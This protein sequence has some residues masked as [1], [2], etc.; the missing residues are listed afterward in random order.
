MTAPTRTSATPTGATL[1]AWPAVRIIAGREISVKIRDKTFIGSTAFLIVVIILLTVLPAILDGGAPDIRVGTVGDTALSVTR[2]AA[3]FG[4][5]AISE[6]ETALPG[7]KL[8]ISEYPDLAAAKRAVDAE[9]IAA[10]VTVSGG[11]LVIV[12]SQSVPDELQELVSAAWTRHQVAA[13]AA[14]LGLTT[15]QV[16]P[17]LS[18]AP[19]ETQLLNARPEGSVPP[20][21]IA[22]IFGF[23]YYLAS[24]LFGNAIA[25][26]VVEEKQSRVVELLVAT[27]RVRQLLAGKVLAATVLALGQVVLLVGLG[28]AG[29]AVTGNTEM[30]SQILPLSGWFLVFFA[31]GMVL[32]ACLWAVSGALASRIE[33]LQSTSLIVTVVVMAPFMAIFFVSDPGPAMT[34][35]SYIPLT[36]IIFMPMR[37]AFEVA[38][39]WEPLLSLGITVA[40]VWITVLFA[41]RLYS[42][43]IMHTASLLK[44]KDAWRKTSEVA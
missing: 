4:E 18:P 12:G 10:A 29:A 39:P 27:V 6:P 22:F 24:L 5:S 16:T 2:D 11:Q 17:L 20:L 7:A 21:L 43:S 31:F 1:R 13:E 23:L 36:S 42:A 26:S 8:H 28:L 40:A 19:V 34:V 25:Q 33:E 9:E 3:A 14:A 38:A 32:Q 41:S 30:L 35:L 44:V 37:L 15:D